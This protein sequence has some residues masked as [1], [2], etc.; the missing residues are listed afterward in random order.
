MEHDNTRD[1]PPHTQ[2][3]SQPIRTQSPGPGQPGDQPEHSLLSGPAKYIG[4]W[5]DQLRR[6]YRMVAFNLS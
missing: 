3:V 5:D 2:S 4:E 6:D 1:T